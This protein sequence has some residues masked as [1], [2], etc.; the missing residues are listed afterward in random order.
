MFYQYVFPEILGAWNSFFSPC[1]CFQCLT[2]DRLCPSN[3][4]D[5]PRAGLSQSESWDVLLSFW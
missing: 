4:K 1:Q 2:A 5:L 3:G